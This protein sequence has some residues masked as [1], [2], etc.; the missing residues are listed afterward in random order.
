MCLICER[1][2]MIENGT[3]PYFVKELSTGYV[4]LGDHQHFKG[5]TLNLLMTIC[6]ISGFKCFN[7]DAKTFESFKSSDSSS[8]ASNDTSR[9][10]AKSLILSSFGSDFP[11]SQSETDCLLIPSLLTR[12]RL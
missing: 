12:E 9:T 3:N 6:L 1:I 11:F 7:T 8:K 5:Y 2:K 4:V 10:L